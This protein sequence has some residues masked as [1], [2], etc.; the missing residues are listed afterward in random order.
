M[1]HGRMEVQYFML[2]ALVS[3]AKSTVYFHSP[4]LIGEDAK[5]DS[6]VLLT[7]QVKIKPDCLVLCKEKSDCLSVSLNLQPSGG[8]HECILSGVTAD[9]EY[10]SLLTELTGWRYFEKVTKQLQAIIFEPIFINIYY[11]NI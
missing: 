8:T 2:S 3:L 11:S 5:L 6:G 7:E 10:D 9:E 4:S 1:F